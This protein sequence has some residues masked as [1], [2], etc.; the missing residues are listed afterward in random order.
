M[1]HPNPSVLTVDE[2]GNVTAVSNGWATVMAVDETGKASQVELTVFLND[3]NVR[4]SGDVDMDG[5]VS[6]A[7]I[8]LIV[9]TL[10]GGWNVRIWEPQADVNADGVIDL[11]DVVLIRRCLAGGWGVTLV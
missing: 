1:K 3:P 9:R 10:A 2:N 5:E 4:V 6:T 7:D 11:K 8:V